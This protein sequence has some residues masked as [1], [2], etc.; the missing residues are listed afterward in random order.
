METMLPYCLCLVWKVIH[1]LSALFQVWTV[2]LGTS[3]LHNCYFFHLKILHTA[4]AAEMLGIFKALCRKRGLAWGRFI[5]RALL[6][7]PV[8]FVV[9][10]EI[11]RALGASVSPW[12]L[13]KR[14]P[15]RVTSLLSQTIM[16]LVLW[17][18]VV[19]AFF[20][21]GYEA[22]RCQDM[23]KQTTHCREGLSL[24]HM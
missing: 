4:I 22:Q 5:W 8:V 21:C 17:G 18:T 19:V 20:P 23:G 10:V 12:C 3:F 13:P 7:P 15:L 6:C 16:H 9:S 11:L 14:A 24:P 2:P 1:C